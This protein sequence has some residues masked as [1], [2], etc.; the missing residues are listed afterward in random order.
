MGLQSRLGRI[1]LAGEDEIENTRGRP[2][3]EYLKKRTAGAS[4]DEADAAVRSTVEGIISDVKSRG[5]VA[6]REL[7]QR[8]DRWA[9]PSFRLSSTEIESLVA[10]VPAETIADIRFAQTQI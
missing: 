2:M 3:A 5:D 1:N 6:V 9:P 10:S 7:S 8:F 4:A